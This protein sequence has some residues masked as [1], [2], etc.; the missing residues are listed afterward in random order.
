M[1]DRWEDGL[2]LANRAIDLSSD[3][4][5]EILEIPSLIAKGYSCVRSKHGMLNST[6]SQIE[7]FL[8]N[9]KISI[10]KTMFNK[11]QGEDQPDKDLSLIERVEK[12]EIQE[13]LSHAISVKEKMVNSGPITN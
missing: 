12:A 9:T 5:R 6:L 13:Y 11:I 3:N 7:I 10:P 4:Q 2:K 1:I 8:E